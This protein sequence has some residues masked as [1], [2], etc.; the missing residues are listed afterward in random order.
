[1]GLEEK[2]PDILQNIESAVTQFYRKSPDLRD[3]DVMKAYELLERH[4]RKLSMGRKL[5][6]ELPDELATELYKQVLSTLEVRQKIIGTA[7][8]SEAETPKRRFSHALKEP[9]KEEIIIAC[10]RKV[11]KSAK[12]WNKRNGERGYL[13]FV[14]D[15]V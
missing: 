4:F 6:E 5:E 11:H 15:Y 14:V 13:G 7:D 12:R 8:N 1:M 3:R 2:Y 9:S 10:L